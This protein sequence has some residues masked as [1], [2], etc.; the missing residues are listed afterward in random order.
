M[1]KNKNKKW[2]SHIVIGVS[3]LVLLAGCG[4]S[5]AS[6][7]SEVRK[8]KVAYDQASKPITW[9]DENGKATGYDVEAMRLVDELLP[10]YEFEFIGTSNDDLLLGVEQGKYQ[11]GIKNAFWTEERTKKFIFPKEFLGLSSMGLVVKKKNENIKTLADFATAGLELAPIAANNA[12]YAIIDEYNKANPNNQV[13]LKAG[14]TFSIDIVQWVNENRVDG[15]AMIEGLFEK[16]VVDKDGPYHNLA[17]DIVY[18]EFAVIKTWPLFNKKEQELA[19]AYDT[20]I[21]KV[22]DEKKLEE[23]SVKFYGKDLFDVL[24][25]VKR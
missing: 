12:Q 14:D 17:N 11:I 23:L 22:K 16:Q 2:F 13:K 24:N 18:N 3:L 4:T 15:G 20:A 5:K 21:K 25:K 6:S 1:R 8:I 19:D 10:Q 9:L 7:G